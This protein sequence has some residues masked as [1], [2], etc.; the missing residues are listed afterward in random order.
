M[1]K[2]RSVLKIAG[3]LLAAV[4]V[5]YF[6]G[7]AVSALSGK[8]TELV[9]EKRDYAVNAVGIKEVRVRARNMPV[10]VTPSGGDEITIHYFTC[11]EDPYEVSLD[12]GVLTLAYKNDA[13]T[14]IS[15]WF[16]GVF[17]VFSRSNPEVGVVLPADYAGKLSLDTSNAAVNVSGLTAAG[18]VRLESSNAPIG[19]SSV[20]AALLDARTSNGG[21]TLDVVAVSGP[22]DARTS[23]GALTARQVVARDR[24]RMETSNGRVTVDRVAAADIELRSS[25]GSI[26]GSVEG[27]RAD[28]TIS[29]HTSNGYDSL[30]DGGK[31]QF[32][33]TVQTSNGNIDIRFLGE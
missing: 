30:G 3:V 9:Y 6:A 18:E 24:L 11:E 20:S 16:F 27:K 32:R 28:Y 29:S 25:N 2:K 19:V 4:L 23:N 14:T 22:A 13:L 12:G 10:R 31:G 21:V 26:T 17:R 5:V 8:A 15:Q 33:L 1:K 7:I